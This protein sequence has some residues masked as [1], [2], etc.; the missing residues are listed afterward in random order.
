MIVT[1]VWALVSKP[2]QKIFEYI[3]DLENL[4]FYNSSVLAAHWKD[5]AKLVCFLKI[6]LPILNFEGDY[7]IIQLEENQKIVASCKHSLMEFEDTYE[8][9]E[10]DGQIEIIITDK[11]Q[12]KG[13][14]TLSEGILKPNMKRE[15]EAN[16]KKLKSILEA[17]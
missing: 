10:V 4:P 2:K 12:L 5:E 15:M 8:L 1:Q 16:M 13:I 6:G 7:K 17:L 11:I 9:Q 3:R 14:L